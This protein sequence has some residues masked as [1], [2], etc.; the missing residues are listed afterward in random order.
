[1]NS[2]E[3]KNVLVTGG[4]GFIG[5]HLCDALLKESVN[6]L[7]VIDNLFTGKKRNLKEAIEH[8][9][10]HFIIG[11][12][13]NFKLLNNIVIEQ[14]IDVIFNFSVIPLPVSLNQPD[15]CNEQNVIMTQ[16]VCEVI[17]RSKKIITLIH[18]SSSEVYGTARYTPMDEMHP[19]FAHTSYA[20]SKAATDFLVYSYYKTFN[21]DMSI[22]RPFNNF[23]P[24]QNEANYAGIIPLTIKRILKNEKPVIYGDGK[25]TR[26]YIY[27]KDTAKCAID[28]YK[29]QNTRGE[30]INIGSGKQTE[31]LELVKNICKAMNYKNEIDFQEERPGDVR[32]HQ[33]DVK[34]AEKLID[35]KSKTSIEQE[36]NETVKWYIKNI[37]LE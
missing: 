14:E 3:N 6:K 28:I 13:T 17:R 7:I 5:S 15:F 35:F 22:I 29:N 25:Q 27:A 31:I 19:I 30:I 24:R 26:D 2:L 21:I 18:C 33:A 9:N 23:G 1:M 16:N 4:A 8:K 12:V 37:I 34:K 36:V 10:F 20:A 32:V 11:D